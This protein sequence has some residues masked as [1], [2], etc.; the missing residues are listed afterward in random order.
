MFFNFLSLSQHLTTSNTIIFLGIIKCSLK[1][2]ILIVVYLDMCEAGFWSFGSNRI[3]SESVI[4]FM[5]RITTSDSAF[6]SNQ[7]RIESLI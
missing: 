6:G 3:E 5:E 7:Y 4:R 1:H 2:N